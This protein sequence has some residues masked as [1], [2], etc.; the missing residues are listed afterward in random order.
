MKKL[1]FLV[2]LFSLCTSTFV[3]AQS[4]ISQKEMFA[5]TYHNSKIIAESQHYKFI[6]NVI[7]NSQEREILDDA[8]NEIRINKLDVSG[9]LH[10]F[11]KESAIYTLKDS[12]SKI[13]TSF[14][15]DN[16]QISITIKT[17]VYDVII[18]VKPNGNAF[19]TL[20]RDGSSNILYTGKLV[21]L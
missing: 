1:V 4:K 15:D 3:T 11:S 13:D 18:E 14:N 5:A 2:L 19:L 20:T 10:G 6:A 12:N 21:E 7:H 9:Q 16:Q 8:I 17:L